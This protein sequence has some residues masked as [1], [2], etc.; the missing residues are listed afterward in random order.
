MLWIVDD[1]TDGSKNRCPQR[2]REQT[3]EDYK[4]S[5]IS[6]T[7]HKASMAK[8]RLTSRSRFARIG[9][10]EELKVFYERRVGGPRF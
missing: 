9:L 4:I 7:R 8:P 1:A 3:R 10:N 2:D 6:P 5:E